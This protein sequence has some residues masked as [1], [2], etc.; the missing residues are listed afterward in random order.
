MR[1]GHSIF[2]KVL[3][4]PQTT[5]FVFLKNSGWYI[6]T[7]GGK[8]PGYPTRSSC[9][10]SLL[11]VEC[12]PPFTPGA[13]HFPMSPAKGKGTGWKSPGRSPGSIWAAT[14]HPGPERHSAKARDL[15]TKISPPFQKNSRSEF[16]AP[17]EWSIAPTGRN[18][19]SCSPFRV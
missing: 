9:S 12:R 14:A 4:E 5:F 17:T 1:K 8:A 13:T 2:G 7:G 11:V 16:V 3:E 10:L 19:R 15:R 6:K 18:P